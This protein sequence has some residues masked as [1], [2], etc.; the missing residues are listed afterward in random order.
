MSEPRNIKLLGIVGMPG[1]GKTEIVDYIVS[2]GWPRIYFGG[3][4]YDEM[5]KAGVEITPES[6][7]IFREQLREREGKD[8]IARRALEYIGNL[9]DAGQKNIVIDGIYSWPEYKAV[10]QAYRELELVA[11]V[12]PRRVR[13]HRLAN[14]PERPF[15]KEEAMHRDYTEIENIEKGGPIAIADHYIVNTG[16]LDDL[17]HKIDDI[18]NGAFAE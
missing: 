10:K 18:M 4:M 16:S 3:I 12:A 8:F 17:H 11:V 13:H 7:Q 1:A 15:T 5:T 6:Q 14:R 2:Q 9:I